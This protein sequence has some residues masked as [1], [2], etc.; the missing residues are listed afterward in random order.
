MEES[1]K[2]PRRSFWVFI[3]A[4]IVEKKSRK[5]NYIARI[6][7]PFLVTGRQK[8]IGLSAFSFQ[9]YSLL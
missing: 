7:R 1:K 6:A 9:G 4:A 5:K 2:F 8:S 3:I